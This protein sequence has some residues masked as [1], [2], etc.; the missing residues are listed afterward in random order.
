MKKQILILILGVLPTFA[1][2][3]GGGVHLESAP[4]DISDMESVKR[5]AKHFIDYCFSCHEASYM[6][7]NRIARD[8]GMTDAELR[9]NLIFT[10]NE[11]GEPTKVGS[12][13]K[14]AMTDDYARTAFGT[15]APDLTL[16]ARSRGADW[17]YTYLHSFYIDP[18]RP[19]GM[20]NL[21]FPDVG[22]PNVLSSLQGMQKAVY[23][24][25][26]RQGVEVES[27]DHLELA[28]AGSM[29]EEEYDAF[30]TDLVNFMVYLAE[31]VQNERRSLGIKVL[32]FL[33]VFFVL[34]YML[35]K[36]Y[37]KDVH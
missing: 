25:E 10:T 16:T 12:L 21:V 34:A 36:E 26:T 24:T 5:G 11:K 14:V 13:M 31:P 32:I 35:K 4:I 19:T 6:R 17:V 28:Q 2:A 8:T 18:Y 22:M 27:V 23:K 9:E 29:T 30:V 20:N 37:W 15:P 3:S 1:F 7:Y 33:V